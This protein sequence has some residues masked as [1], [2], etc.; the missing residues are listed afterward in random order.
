MGLVPKLLVAIA[1]AGA[2]APTR[3]RAAEAT[4]V[5]SGGE[6][7]AGSF[8]FVLSLAWRRDEKRAAIKREVVSEGTRTV[9][10]DL[11]FEQTRNILDLRA[12]VGLFGD[13]SLYAVT[14]IVLA[15]DRA[16]HFDRSGNCAAV[17]CVD[18]NSSTLLRDGILPGY[19]APM[20]GWDT[21]HDRS[22]VRG[23]ETVFR[24]PTRRGLEYLGLGFA[25]A[26]FNERRDDTKPTWVI[27]AESRFSVA[28][29][30]RF[31]RERPRANRGVGLGYHQLVGE[32][33]FSRRFGRLDPYLGGTFM[34]PTLTSSSPYRRYTLGEGAY[35]RPQVRAMAN[36]GLQA[37]A[38]ENAPAHQRIDLELRGRMELRFH[39]LAQSELWEVLSGSE[40]C[41]QQPAT[42]R[43][44]IDRDLTGD[45]SAEPH[46]G[47][48]RSPSYGLFGGDVGLVVRAGR[49]VLFRGL[50]GMTWEQDRFVTDARSG[51]QIYDI[52]GR[53]F[54]VEGGRLW[55]LFAEGVLRF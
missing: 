49:L 3:A 35:S 6:G 52:P 5:A 50:V 12:D 13:L 36:A 11:V 39:G 14:P 25:W 55:H 45:G 8:D 28:K 32:M 37:T 22:F 38:W 51:W 1:V 33:A 24:G 26:V 9:R 31:D 46:P 44:E 48:T 53:R 47:V 21:E 29:D 27:R 34:F 23:S 54:R 4:R 43:R 18:E 41:P 30:M 2:L 16:L 7:T 10:R 42:C 20:F 19:E 40:S 17:A 15:D